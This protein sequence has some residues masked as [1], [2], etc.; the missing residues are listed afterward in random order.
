MILRQLT[1][2]ARANGLDVKKYLTYIFEN[3]R[4]ISITDLLP[5]S[6]NIVKKFKEI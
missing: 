4:N 3:H 6:E 1:Q 5:Y 2:T